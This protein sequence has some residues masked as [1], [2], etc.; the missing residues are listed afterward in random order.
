MKQLIAGKRCLKKSTE[1]LV[2]GSLLKEKSS[3]PVVRK[4]NKTKALN[5]D[6]QLLNFNKRH[7]SNSFILKQNNEKVNIVE[8]NDEN[9]NNKKS[10]KR[11]RKVIILLISLGIVISNIETLESKGLVNSSLSNKI[12]ALKKQ[13][14]SLIMYYAQLDINNGSNGITLEKKLYHYLAITFQ[15]IE[16]IIRFSKIGLIGVVSLVDYFYSMNKEDWN[17]NKE[18]VH[19]RNAERFLDLFIKLGGIYVKIGQYMSTMNNFLP[20]SW[21]DVMSVLQD[22]VPSQLNLE[23][24]KVL[25]QEEYKTDPNLIFEWI[26]EEPI[27]AASLAQ[28]HR[29]KLLNSN[30]IVV[31]KAQYPSIRYY[32]QG[33]T[34]TRNFVI[35]IMHGLFPEYDISWLGEKLD[36]VLRR[37]LNFKLEMANAEKTRQHFESND[38]VYIPKNYEQLSTER[39]L[40]M[41][42]INDSI[43]ID[44][45]NELRKQ[46]G[47]KGVKE[48]CEITLET[49]ARMIFEFGEIHTDPHPGNL[50]IRK[51]PNR[52]GKVQLVLLDHGLYQ[53][54][55]STF[56]INFCKLWKA[57]VL[58]DDEVIKEYCKN[59]GIDDYQLYASFVLMR[60]YGDDVPVGLG[61]HATRQ[62]LEQF[63]EQLVSERMNQF[64]NLIRNIP[65]EMLLI[66]RTNNALRFI[67]QQL[68]IPV[69]RYVIN[70]RIA[71][72]CLHLENSLSQKKNVSFYQRVKQFYFSSVESIHFEFNLHYYEWKQAL[73]NWI[74]KQLI[75]FKLMKPIKVNIEKNDIDI[76]LFA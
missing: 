68:G 8:I 18:H 16:I 63:V 69:N 37:E 28:V 5:L 33:D 41:E 22:S 42:C 7:F 58:K 11:L 76:V 59:Y 66:M 75:Y 17:E 51:H 49:F 62:E 39:V 4:V 52:K 71:S 9:N 72:K 25:L 43:K 13:V 21:T 36:Q 57:L 48:A 40:V 73:W 15:T 54:L 64:T 29:A 44:Q 10:S 3:Y 50:L 19:R 38:L 27:A 12:S 20:K 35:T 55:D 47:E 60:G 6:Q 67:N 53:T 31:I 14:K 46:F 74:Y 45:V 23:E 26:E 2:I 1:A 65:N 30:E 70:A 61:T 32:Y 34:L 56:R 24:L